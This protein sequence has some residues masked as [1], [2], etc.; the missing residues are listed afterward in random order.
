MRPSRFACTIPV[1]L[2][3]AMLGLILALA[4]WA[5]SVFPFLGRYLDGN[6]TDIQGEV[7]ARQSQAGTPYFVYLPPGYKHNSVSYPLV[8]H[9]HGALLSMPERAAT[10]VVR[11]DLLTLAKA[12]EGQ[13]AKGAMAPHIIIAPFDGSGASM[14]S[15]AST[16]EDGGVQAEATLMEDILPRARAH[17][18]I[19]GG[20]QNTT[21]QGFSMGGYGAAKIG[22]KYPEQ[23]GR[24]ISWDGALHDWQSLQE[25]RPKI[26]R[27]MFATESDYQ[28]HSPWHFARMLANSDS[29]TPTLVFFTGEMAAPARYTERYLA[30]LDQL[31]I[32]YKHTVTSCPHSPFCFFTPERVQAAYQ[33]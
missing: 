14:W 18:R 12:M 10:R 27:T 7:E 30:H 19:V 33:P 22:L 25:H 6:S 9:L 24:I 15:D 26:A 21:I 17:Y 13:V 29:A 2:S 32:Q 1:I 4:A 20:R 11:T 16:S 5:N 31:G 3:V 8:I 23:F 28:S